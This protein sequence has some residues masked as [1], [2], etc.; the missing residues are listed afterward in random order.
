MIFLVFAVLPAVVLRALTVVFTGSAV[1]TVLLH[2]FGQCL[3][4]VVQKE[5]WQQGVTCQ[6]IRE[7]NKYHMTTCGNARL[8][9]AQLAYSHLVGRRTDQ[10]LGFPPLSGRLRP[11]GSD[12]CSP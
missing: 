12:P 10:S 11:P 4:G 2:L 8:V 9:L 5:V 3:G 7:H 6:T 1:F